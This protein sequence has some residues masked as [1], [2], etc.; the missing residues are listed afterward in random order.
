MHFETQELLLTLTALAALA[1]ILLVALI[2][3]HLTDRRRQERERDETVDALVESVLATRSELG[4]AIRE[5]DARLSGAMTGLLSYVTTEQKRAGDAV[6]RFSGAARTDLA[7]MNTTLAEE[8]RGLQGMMDGRFAKVLETN[9]GAAEALGR[10]LEAEMKEVRG[11][12]DTALEKMRAENEKKLEAMRSTVAEKLEATLTDRISASFR[13]VDEKLGLV[14]S[15]LGEMREMARSVS[16]L[17]N[18]LANVKTR[19]TFGEVQLAAILDEVLA[20]GQ[21]G[22]QV[23]VKPGSAERVDFA[24]RLPGRDPAEPCWLP[25]D[26][27]FPLEDW[28][29]LEAAEREGD[30]ERAAAARK[31]LERALVKQAKSI[32]EKYVNPPVTTEFAVMFLPSEGLYAE[33]LRTPGLADRL[34]REFRITPAG[35]TVITALLNSLLMGFMTLAMEERST[36]VWRILS[37]VKTE[38]TGFTKQF[39]TVERKFR[40]AQTS[41]EQMSA[42]SRRMGAKMQ[43]IDSLGDGPAAAPALPAESVSDGENASAV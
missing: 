20:P 18:I 42:R 4:G 28:E 21:Y 41:L 10:R 8:F 12:L 40:E 26:S 15:G 37:E 7:R 36:E 32:H 13:R 2:T 39:E 6:E 3:L 29:A 34:Q 31:G 14:E 25:I 16:R 30:P 17:Q 22:S 11:T 43:G 19:G 35:P 24:V 27:K 38:F 33:A 5:T 1:V 9:A 23:K